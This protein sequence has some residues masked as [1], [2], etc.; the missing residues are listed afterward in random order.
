VQKKIRW[1]LIKKT[2]VKVIGKAGKAKLPNL[3]S[4]IHNKSN[5]F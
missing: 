1:M 5:P 3:K 2:A 4:M